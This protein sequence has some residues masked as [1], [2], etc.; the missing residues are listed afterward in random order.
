M[1]KYVLLLRG[2]NVGGNKIVPMADLKKMLE[3]SGYRNVKTLLASGNVLLEAEEKKAEQLAEAIGKK[4]EKTFGFDS[5]MIVRTT[6]QIEELVQSEPFKAIS[7]TPDTRLYVTFLSGKPGSTL[8]IP[9]TSPDGGFRILRVFEHEV[10]SVLTLSPKA[11]T[12]KAMDI[13]EKEFGKN[14]TTRN[15]NTVMKL[16]A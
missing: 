1:M 5:H 14:I 15:W 4:F 11:N 12:V 7:V 3:K 13:L 2:I 16:I 8:T 6:K 10:C 9:Y